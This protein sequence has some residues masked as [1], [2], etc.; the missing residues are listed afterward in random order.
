MTAPRLEAEGVSVRFGNL[1]ALREVSMQVPAGRAVGLIGPNGAGKSTLLDVLAGDLTPHAGRVAF[2]GADIGRLPTHERARRGL[3]RTFQHLELFDEMT[4]LDNVLVA[5]A[6][7][8]SAS[9][10]ERLTG[11]HARASR[12]AALALLDSLGLAAY[13]ELDVRV[14]PF[15][16]RR[17][18]SYARAVFGEPRCLLLDEPTAGLTEQERAR[19]AE[20]L[21][22]DVGDGGRSLVLVEHDIGFVAGV[23]DVIYVLCVGEVIARGDFAAIS[24]SPAV[25]EAYLG[26]R[27]PSAETEV[28]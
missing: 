12:R 4:V 20:R 27:D 13:A 19:F 5:G 1:W 21:R 26:H 10:R 3:R 23:C 24:A 9:W 28:G 16:V 7:Q 6:G 18:V 8:R 22:Q 11:R 15:P 14:L 2:G 17:L 25:R